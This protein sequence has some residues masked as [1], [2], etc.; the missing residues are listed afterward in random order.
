[1]NSFYSKEYVDSLRAVGSLSRLFSDNLAPFLHYRVMENLFCSCFQAENISRSDIAYDAKINN[2]GVGL[3]T[4]VCDKNASI[5][6]I[7]EFNKLSSIIKSK[8]GNNESLAQYLGQ[9]RNDRIRVANEIYGITHSLYHVIARR[10]KELI[11]F[12]SDYEEID[13]NRIKDIKQTSSSLYFID[14]TNEYFFNFSKSVLQKKFYIP[15]NHSKIDIE[16]IDNPFELLL[17]LKNKILVPTKPKIKGE[18]IILPLF[19]LKGKKH[20]PEKSQLNQWNAGGRTR[21]DDEVY[22]PIPSE[23]YKIAPQFFPPRHISFKIK[24][25]LNEILNATVCQDNGK[26]LMTNPNSALSQWLLRKILKL[27]PKELLTLKKLQELG[28]D[29]V[30]ISKKKDIYIIDVMPCE[31]YENFIEQGGIIP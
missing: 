27:R 25:P 15:K 1:M 8:Q 30:I 20:V 29:S 31:S 2:L 26:A 5:Q 28:F 17:S 7:A 4:F 11:F 22:I 12:E 3:K 24:T 14:G 21:S 6:K 10:Q 9:L 19:S 16:I 23:I 13:I 18:Y